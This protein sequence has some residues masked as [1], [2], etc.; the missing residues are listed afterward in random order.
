MKGFYNYYEHERTKI[1]LFLLCLGSA[2]LGFL[3]YITL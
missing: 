2:N 3:Y 1:Y